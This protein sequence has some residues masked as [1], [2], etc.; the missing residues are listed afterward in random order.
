M[1]TRLKTPWPLRSIST[2]WKLERPDI[3][4]TERT[5]SPGTRPEVS[6]IDPGSTFL[7]IGCTDDPSTLKKDLSNASSVRWKTA[8]IFVSSVSLLSR[9]SRRAG[10][11]PG[12][13]SRPFCAPGGRSPDE[14]RC[15]LS[16]F[17]LFFFSPS[18]AARNRAMRSLCLPLESI[19]S[20]KRLK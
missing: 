10:A 1:T 20:T 4:L 9:T 15:L 7:M 8:P 2:T 6:A 16:F 12:R 3:P 13:V 18:V 17:S 14:D 19:V 5:T 11:A